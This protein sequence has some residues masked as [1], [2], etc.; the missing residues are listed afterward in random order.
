MYRLDKYSFRTKEEADRYLE[1]K[2]MKAREEIKTF[3]VVERSCKLVNEYHK[4]VACGALSSTAGCACGA[5]TY[6]STGIHYHPTFLVT[7]ADGR[8]VVEDVMKSLKMSH[9]WNLKKV[10]YD[11]TYTAPL[12]VVVNGNRYQKTQEGWTVVR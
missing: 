11:L 8:V 12:Y 2:K 6:F 3:N 1:L 4:C 7:E 9:V 5:K 10:L